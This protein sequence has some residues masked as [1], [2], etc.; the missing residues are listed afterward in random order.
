MKQKYCLNI[1]PCMKNDSKYT[2]HI[3]KYSRVICL[4]L[5]PCYLP[6][7]KHQFHK[8]LKMWNAR[9][10]FEPIKV[11]RNYGKKVRV[12]V[13]LKSLRR[14]VSKPVCYGQISPQ[15]AES[16]E[17]QFYNRGTDLDHYFLGPGFIFFKPKY[18][19]DSEE[20]QFQL[21]I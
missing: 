8:Y 16:I 21:I 15:L 1:Y 11:F 18:F 12:C 10:K 3:R 7:Q 6:N 5:L 9:E 20:N 2:A 13:T 19:Y 17:G 4:S 14:L